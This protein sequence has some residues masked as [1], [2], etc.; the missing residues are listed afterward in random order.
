MELLR[1]EIS[2]ELISVNV[3]TALYER[4]D[5]LYK[6]T[7]RFGVKGCWRSVPAAK[8]SAGR[9]LPV[10]ILIVEVRSWSWLV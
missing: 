10:F 8:V 5:K 3:G 6:F 9:D 2:T 1:V 4:A 7:L